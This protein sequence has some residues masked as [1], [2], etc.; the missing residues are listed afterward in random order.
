MRSAALLAKRGPSLLSMSVWM[1]RASGLHTRRLGT[2]LLNSR[3]YARHRCA[4][5]CNLL[6]RG[7]TPQSVRVRWTETP[8]QRLAPVCTQCMPSKD[9]LT[10]TIVDRPSL[11]AFST[12]KTA[13]TG[14][15]T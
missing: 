4:S 1:A 5:V 11:A 13:G 15:G 8:K 7:P 3:I 14:G 12:V 6:G 9:V 2:T 10:D